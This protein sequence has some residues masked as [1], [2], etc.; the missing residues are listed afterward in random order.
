LPDDFNDLTTDEEL[1]EIQETLG[2]DANVLVLCDINFTDMLTGN[3]YDPEGL[4]T[5]RIPVPDSYE[6]GDMLAVVHINDDGTY[7]Y[8]NCE[9]VDGYAVFSTA[10]FSTYGLTVFTGS[11]SDILSQDTTNSLVWLW[12]TLAILAIGVLTALIVIKKQ[13]STRS[14]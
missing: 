3:E 5:V 7:E 4:V 2:E 8:I 12:I 6:E 13:H 10:S 11:L 1:A 9:I 14:E